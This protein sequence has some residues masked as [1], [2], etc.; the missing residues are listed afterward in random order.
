M[1]RNS[2]LI[3]MCCFQTLEQIVAHLDENIQKS[4][5]NRST[6][7]TQA[8]VITAG[9]YSYQTSLLNWIYHVEKQGVKN[10]IVLCFDREIY[11]TVGSLHGVLLLQSGHHSVNE[12]KS[13]S[14]DP[15]IRGNDT[16]HLGVTLLTGLTLTRISTTDCV[17]VSPSPTL[18]FWLV[19]YWG[20]VSMEVPPYLSRSVHP[21]PL[22]CS[23]NVKFHATT[24]RFVVAMPQELS[25]IKF[26]AIEVLLGL[27]KVLSQ[28]RA[29]FKTC[30]YVSALL[31]RHSC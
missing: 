7:T 3:A 1:A 4:A 5:V 11:N 6:F 14:K 19:P 16:Q 13:I 2:T 27:G 21:F 10:Y 25:I 23:K 24:P 20:D 30:F 9:T 8:I 31:S 18:K 22:R 15:R 12:T 29:S 17:F 28:F 26:M